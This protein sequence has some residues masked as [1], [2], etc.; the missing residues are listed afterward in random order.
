M[1]D[2][3][4][5]FARLLVVAH[6]NC[7]ECGPVD[8]IFVQPEIERMGGDGRE[9]GMSPPPIEVCPHER[10]RGT[11]FL[12]ELP[13]DVRC[14]GCH[15]EAPQEV[16]QRFEE[17]RHNLAPGKPAEATEASGPPAIWLMRAGGGEWGPVDRFTC[18]V[19]RRALLTVR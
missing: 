6:K 2:D 9:Q 3:R 7:D 13:S 11:H 16:V 15:R 18:P 19:H 1:M 12:S 5:R 14:E 17:Q 4:P 10:V 8:T